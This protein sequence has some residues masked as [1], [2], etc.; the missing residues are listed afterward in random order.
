MFFDQKTHSKKKSFSKR[1]NELLSNILV[2]LS[3]SSN[4][5][6]CIAVCFRISLNHYSLV[7]LAHFFLDCVV[8]NLI[9]AFEDEKRLASSNIIS[10]HIQ[11]L[12]SL[13]IISFAAMSFYS[14]SF[15]ILEI[16]QMI[17]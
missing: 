13:S 8:F 4:H 11:H 7:V 15:N 6:N 3:Q 10:E 17:L 2:L 1:V 9:L 14:D 5:D 16:I 12:C